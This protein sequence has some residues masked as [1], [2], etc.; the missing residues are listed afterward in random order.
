MTYVDTFLKNCKKRSYT[1]L[2]NKLFEGVAG[3]KKQL[4]KYP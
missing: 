1:Q 4:N 2:H 3:L